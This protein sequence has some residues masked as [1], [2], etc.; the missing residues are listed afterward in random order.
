MPHPIV[1]AHR[2]ACGYRPEHT[3]SAYALAIDLGADF[4]EPDLVSTRDGTL[5]AR[6]ENAMAIVDPSSG[7]VIE[8]TT[9]VADRPE[10]ASRKT[11][12][13]IDGKSMTGWFTEDFTIDELRTLRARER[14]PLLRPGNVAWDGLSAIPT[15]EE[16]IELVKRR[17]RELGRPI[18]I[19]PETKH[20]TYFQSIGLPL[21]PSLIESLHS[22]GFQGPDAPVFIQSFEVGNLRR[23]AEWTS[24]PLIQLIGEEPPFD[25]LISGS[26]LSPAAMVSPAGLRRIREYAA[27][28]GPSKH[29]V[30][31]AHGHGESVNLVDRAHGAGLLVHVWT[32]RSE[33]QFLQPEFRSGESSATGYLRCHGKAAAELQ[34]F[35]EFGVDGVFSDFPDVAVRVRDEIRVGEGRQNPL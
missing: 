22:A 23:L 16:I 11:R 35:F 4:I 14:L 28:I 13:A 26:R 7:S 3:L 27:G 18:G 29:K 15:L 17:G 32:F 21:E 24:L 31:Q 19:Y 6:H 20:P 9:D 8:A 30:L 10:F 34:T 33:N 1:I 2:G 25:Q 12:K 5:V